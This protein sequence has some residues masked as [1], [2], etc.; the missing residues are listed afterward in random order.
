MLPDI[1]QTIAS[2][3]HPRAK[4]RTPAELAMEV[5]LHL[6]RENIEREDLMLYI[7]MYFLQQL[8]Q[9]L[10]LSG[11]EGLTARSR[12]CMIQKLKNLEL[13]ELRRF[14]RALDAVVILTLL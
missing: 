7:S 3:F 10:R 14:S 4:A 6:L 12:A 11:I 1:T 8:R 2:F 9:A 13:H 5:E